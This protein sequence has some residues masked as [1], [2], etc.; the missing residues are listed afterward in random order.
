MDSQ[1][2]QFDQYKLHNTEVYEGYCTHTVTC[3]TGSGGKTE[4]WSKGKT[5]GEG[6]F[7]IV[8]LEREERGALRAVKQISKTHILMNERELLALSALKAVSKLVPSPPVLGVDGFQYPD[9][10]VQLFGWFE[11]DGYI[12]LA[13]EYIEYGDLSNL[14]DA[15]ERNMT[16][17]DAKVITRQLLKGLKIMHE[18]NFCH[19]DLKPMVRTFFSSRHLG[20]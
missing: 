18:N 17:S 16:E 15:H 14:V 1:L 2:S 6:A 4:K 7:G 12:F 19:R 3:E 8:W 11:N 10:F 5:L 9:L 13:M 20:D